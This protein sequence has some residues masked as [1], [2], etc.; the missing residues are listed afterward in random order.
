MR[1]VE[2][3]EIKNW[4][5]GEVGLGGVRCRI[6]VVRADYVGLCGSGMVKLG[7]VVKAFL[8][9]IFPILM[10]RVERE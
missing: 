1:Y 7:V 4:G 3:R 9:R 10:L 2:R 8:L 6:L 5:E